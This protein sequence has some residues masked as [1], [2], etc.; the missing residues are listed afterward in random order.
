MNP[1]RKSAVVTGVF[2]VVAAAAAIVG[3]AFYQGLLRDPNYVLS[4]S[5]N[6][7]PVLLGAFFEVLVVV[8]VIGTAVTLFP[9]VKRWNEGM[10]IGYVAGRTVEGV[11]I[12][13]GIISLLTVVTLRQQ[14]AGEASASAGSLVALQRA[15]VAVHDWTFL[16]GPNLALGV[17]TSLLAYLMFRSGLVPRLIAI[18]GLVG[19]PLIFASGTAEMDDREGIQAV[20]R[21]LRAAEHRCLR[22]CPVSAKDLDQHHPRSDDRRHHHGQ[23]GGHDPVEPAPGLG[24][25]A[26]GPDGKEY[27]PRVGAGNSHR[28]REIGYRQRLPVGPQ[29]DHS[30]IEYPST[31]VES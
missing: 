28:E 2:F 9:I 31:S 3:L 7:T 23:N 4:S 10:A 19:G 21:D 11:V 27:G 20:S 8:S 13:V 15:L 24:D 17:N 29:L 30:A 14:F 18:I 5:A 25:Q 16:F 12:A 1:G 6:D 26:D 22:Q